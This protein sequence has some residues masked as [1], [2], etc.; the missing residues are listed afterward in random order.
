MA[1]TDKNLYAYC[2][3]NP[4]MRVDHGG[5]FWF[6]FLIGAAVGLATQYISDVAENI[7]SGKQGVDI[8]K[9]H[10]SPVVYI[11]SAIQG[12]LATT[13]M[14]NVAYALSTAAVEG[15]E[16]LVDHAISGEE[17]SAEEF[18]IETTISAISAFTNKNRINGNYLEGKYA[19]S[20]QALKTAKSP[21]KI[22]NYKANISSV[23]KT[24][25]YFALKEVKGAF[26]SGTN[27]IIIELLYSRI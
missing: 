3:N 27:H 19:F 21:V 5:E 9:P 23:K 2:D 16:Y 11:S 1:L 25:L 13:G 14:G 15:M 26:E 6:S 8:F 22:A 12:G 7:S 20:K 17:V 10:S 4:V 18:F 24:Y